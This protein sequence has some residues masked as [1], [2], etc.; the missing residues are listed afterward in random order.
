MTSKLDR[1]YKVAHLSGLSDTYP[2]AG[3]MAWTN[4][5]AQEFLVWGDIKVAAKAVAAAEA[6]RD[7]A[8]A[9]WDH[10]VKKALEFEDRASVAEAERDAALAALKQD[11]ALFSSIY[12]AL[13]AAYN[14]LDAGLGHGMALQKI[15][16]ARWEI[17]KRTQ[18][19]AALPTPPSPAAGVKKMSEG[20]KGW[21]QVG[22]SGRE[23]WLQIANIEAVTFD[24]YGTDIV[25]TGGKKYEAFGNVES[26]LERI[27]KAR[28]ALNP[29][30]DGAS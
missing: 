1:A 19:R 28:L 2:V 9:Q 29:R 13:V 23:V 25:M 8:V 4:E 20:R 27:D 11:D 30:G 15:C 10:Y 12:Q 24:G 5:G 3:G 17:E 22:R 7:N 14:K 6:E 21:L 16:S 18:A 26:T